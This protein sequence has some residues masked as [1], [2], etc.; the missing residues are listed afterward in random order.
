[1]CTFPTKPRKAYNR[2]DSTIGKTYKFCDAATLTPRARYLFYKN[3]PASPTRPRARVSW[4]L[5]PS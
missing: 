5:L 1:M 2:D 3:G 4:S